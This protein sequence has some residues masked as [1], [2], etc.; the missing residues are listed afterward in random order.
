QDDL[1]STTFPLL[2]EGGGLGLLSV[3]RQGVLSQ[4]EINE[5]RITLAN[6][7]DILRYAQIN[8]IVQRDT[9]RSAFMSE[10][11]NLMSYTTMG[12]GD[13]LFMVVNI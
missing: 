8:D 12:L 2:L 4:D 9:F 5:I 11:T 10:I 6:I 3:S 1:P 7:A 13:A